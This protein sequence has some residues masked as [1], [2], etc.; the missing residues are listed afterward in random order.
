[1]STPPFC[2]SWLD[3]LKLGQ[4]T[5][6]SCRFLKFGGRCGHWGFLELSQKEEPPQTPAAEPLGLPWFLAPSHLH[7]L[8]LTLFREL[9]QHLSF[10]VYIG[11]SWFPLLTNQLG[12]HV[13]P[14]SHYLE[15]R[16]AVFIIVT[17]YS[18]LHSSM[19]KTQDTRTSLIAQQRAEV[20][21]YLIH[22]KSKF[23][24]VDFKAFDISHTSESREQ[25]W[26]FCQVPK[27]P[28]VLECHQ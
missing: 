26:S 2:W 28:S 10:F 14:W 5:S 11:W 4:W 21:C 8:P 17:E 1:M 20:A 24:R 15:R 19:T 13:R 25:G 16:S 18:W 22:W 3:W 9:P 7:C 6:F 27:Q 23:L 12:T